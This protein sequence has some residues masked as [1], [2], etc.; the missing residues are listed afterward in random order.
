MVEL[1][2]VDLKGR[3]IQTKIVAI[4]KYLLITPGGLAVYLIKFNYSFRG[5]SPKPELFW[6]LFHLHHP[7]ALQVDL[8]LGSSNH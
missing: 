8:G 5:D 3:N 7:N 1:S 6:V 2:V 4:K